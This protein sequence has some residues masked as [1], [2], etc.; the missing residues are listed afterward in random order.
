MT[1]KEMPHITVEQ[2]LAL[3]DAAIKLETE[4]DEFVA[5][6]YRLRDLIENKTAIQI[7]CGQGVGDPTSPFSCCGMT[8]FDWPDDV[9]AVLSET[10]SQSLEALKMQW[11]AE[12]DKLKEIND[13][14]LE[15]LE[16]VVRTLESDASSICDTIWVSNGSP[17]TLYDH[18]RAAIA[19]AEGL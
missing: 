3:R 7:C 19:K 9:V 2:V 10:P 4:R 18:C 11:R 13:E 6:I 12:N 16:E 1:I 15:A 5:H 17:E 8:N 14:L